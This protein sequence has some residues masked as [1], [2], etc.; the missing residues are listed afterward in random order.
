MSTTPPEG[1]GTPAPS[2]PPLDTATAPPELTTP[3]A[4]DPA[5]PPPAQPAAPDTA[6]TTPA[7]QPSAP[8]VP[9][10]G[11]ASVTAQPSDLAP[12]SDPGY[13]SA[14]PLLTT[15]AYGFLVEELARLLAANGY[16]NKVAAGVAPPMLDD[17]LMRMVRAFQEEQAIEPHAMQGEAAPL[18]RRD[19]EGIVE[20]ATWRALHGVEDVAA[21][22]EHEL[23]AVD[24]RY[25]VGAFA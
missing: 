6:Q 1:A 23:L 15:G 2:T 17:E 12:S 5:A 13:V 3:A 18:V 19:H 20:A 4:T 21:A 11:G 22:G 7:A 14:L 16:P 8:L 10:F 24:R 9:Q 25:N